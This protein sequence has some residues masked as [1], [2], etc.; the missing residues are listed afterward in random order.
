MILIRILSIKSQFQYISKLNHLHLQLSYTLNHPSKYLTN[1][2][3][4]CIHLKHL[5]L[6]S[7]PHCAISH[8]SHLQP[9]QVSNLSSFLYT[10]SSA[11]LILRV[12]RKNDSNRNQ[13]KCLIAPLTPILS[14]VSHLD[15]KRTRIRK[16]SVEQ[17]SFKNELSRDNFETTRSGRRERERERERERDFHHLKFV[18][19]PDSFSQTGSR[20]RPR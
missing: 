6:N 1:K 16:E 8:S 17:S 12:P 3:G 11:F 9:K 15:S 2:P 18:W 19:P 7:T 5:Q 10:S 4:K 20:R 13:D 14:R